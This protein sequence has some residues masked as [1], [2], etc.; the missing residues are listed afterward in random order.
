MGTK[1]LFGM[2]YIFFLGGGF[3]FLL[4]A[5]EVI[6]NILCKIF[7]GVRRWWNRLGEDEGVSE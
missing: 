4:Y 2:M 3:A 5:G 1:L 7:P 6:V